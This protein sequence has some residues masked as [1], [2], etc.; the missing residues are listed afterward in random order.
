[1]DK[2]LKK[3][4]DTQAADMNERLYQMHNEYAKSLKAEAHSVP[5][6]VGRE[7]ATTAALTAQLSESLF[8]VAAAK[9]PC[10]E[11]IQ[12]FVSGLL[13]TFVADQTERLNDPK[14]HEAIQDEFLVNH[15]LL[16]LYFGYQKAEVFYREKLKAFLA[17][18][19][20]NSQFSF[21]EQYDPIYFAFVHNMLASVGNQQLTLV[22]PGFAYDEFFSQQ[23]PLDALQK[24]MDIHVQRASKGK[25]AKDPLEYNPWTAFPLEVLAWYRVA[26]LA[27]VEVKLDDSYAS[28]YIQVPFELKITN[29]DCLHLLG[30]VSELIGFDVVERYL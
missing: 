26:Q 7:Y 12:E 9:G 1:M 30:D 8:K 11:G 2:K 14:Y 3:I 28:Q 22:Q 25:G 13:T 17:E 4:I 29:K 20:E 23:V 24:L 15:W 18:P 10:A 21:P 27:G 6:L 19:L 16:A 5:G